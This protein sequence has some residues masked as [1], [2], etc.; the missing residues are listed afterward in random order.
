VNITKTISKPS[1]V[2]AHSESSF[3]FDKIKH[4]FQ[5]PS[6]YTAFQHD[7]DDVRFL[8]GT[9]AEN[10]VHFDSNGRMP[11][12]CHAISAL[13]LNKLRNVEFWTSKDI[14]KVS[15]NMTFSLIPVSFMIDMV[16][17]KLFDQNCC[18]LPVICLTFCTSQSVSFIFQ[19]KNRVTQKLSKFDG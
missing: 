19:L 4:R 11:S 3:E 9:I 2:C 8:F 18:F 14:D 16:A 6:L 17:D 5:I 7:S 15:L 1:N 13:V 10:G 12:A